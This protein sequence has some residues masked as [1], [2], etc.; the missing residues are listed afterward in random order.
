MQTWQVGGTG[1]SVQVFALLLCLLL[2]CL[3]A[4]QCMLH[5]CW[6][7]P[8]IIMFHSAECGH[9]EMLHN[10]SWFSRI[11]SFSFLCT[12]IVQSQFQV[13]LR[14]LFKLCCLLS[15][16]YVSKLGLCTLERSGIKLHLWDSVSYISK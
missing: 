3:S 14:P 2:L 6:C 12:I 16:G 1:C 10:G 8:H 7:G 9:E 11:V 5:L 4:Q 13:R 15:V